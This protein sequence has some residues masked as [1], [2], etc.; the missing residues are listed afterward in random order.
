MTSK[1]I[2]VAWV[3]KTHHSGPY[4]K[5]GSFLLVLLDEAFFM[6]GHISRKGSRREQLKRKDV[7]WLG[8]TNTH[9]HTSTDT[10]HAGLHPWTLTV[11][12]R[13]S[14][15]CKRSTRRFSSDLQ[16]IGG[17]SVACRQMKRWFKHRVQVYSN[18]WEPATQMHCG[19]Q[20]SYK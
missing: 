4:H 18:P 5:I 2:V 12:T 15:C 13:C 6:Q 20:C 8:K 11:F 9:R 17:W 1:L 16:P 3:S 10:A 7:L 14:C 19:Y